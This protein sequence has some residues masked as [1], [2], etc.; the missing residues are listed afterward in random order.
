MKQLKLALILLGAAA[1]MPAL[2][3]TQIAS[4]RPANVA[5]HTPEPGTK[6]RSATMNASR[7]PVQKFYKGKRPT[8]VSVREFRVRGGWT[9]LNCEV[10]DAKG[11][12]LETEMH[13]DFSASLKLEKGKWRVVEWGYHGDVVEISRAMAHPEV[14]LNVLGLKPS[15]VR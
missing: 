9:H 2:L 11:R 3:A 6:E 12:P 4:A 15:D 13:L 5:I 10:V 7:L 14:P 1:L 8:F